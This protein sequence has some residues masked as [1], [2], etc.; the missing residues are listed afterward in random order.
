MHL[1][2]AAGGAVAAVALGTLVALGSGQLMAAESQQSAEQPRVADEPSATAATAGNPLEMTDG[3]HVDPTS[4]PATWVAQNP[5]DERVEQ[6]GS[7]IADQPMAKWF[8]GW[9]TD[10][11][12]DV[13]E[14]LGG[15]EAAGA[16]PVLVAY[17][18]PGRDCG[19]HSGGGAENAAEYR[20]WIDTFASAI[21]D[22]PALVVIEPDALAQ[23]DACPEHADPDTRL[24]LLRYAVDQLGAHAP[25]TWSYLDAGNSDWIAAD[26]M[27]GRLNDAGLADAH[28]FAVNVSN[29]KTTED[30]IG[31]SESVN[32]ELSSRFD[33]SR[34]FV[35]DTSRNGN[36]PLGGEWCNPAGR[37]L[38]TPPQ[39]GGG[40][41]ML[42][43]IKVPGDSDGNCGIAPDVPAGTFS[44]D[45]A[46]H[47]IEGS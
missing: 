7:E 6:I 39:E 38:G 37:M 19:S 23:L 17:N 25:N 9:N 31:F 30:S 43:W 35:V 16:L 12:G 22:S 2:K 21:G 24:E 8:G 15:A 40:A 1:P 36:G 14:Y 41:E 4:N 11:A 32:A 18:I 47:L 10:L 45:L 3:F 20:A 33:Y 27:A 42:L 29:Y 28:G 13:S 44:P 5:D 34:P 26:V 46:M